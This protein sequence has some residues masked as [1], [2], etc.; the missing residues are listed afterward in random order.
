MC[1]C[2]FAC[3]CVCVYVR[4]CVCVYMCVRVCVC[5]SKS[6]CVVSECLYCKPHK[7]ACSTTTGRGQFDWDI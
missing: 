4:I 5:I 2:V 7:A 3:M 6:E 1:A